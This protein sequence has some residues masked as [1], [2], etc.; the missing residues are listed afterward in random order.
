MDFDSAF[1]HVVIVEKGFQQDPRDRG[2]WTGGAVGKGVCKG[3]KFGISA[4]AYPAENI[5]NLT[6]DRARQIYH[7]DYWGPAGCD[8]APAELKLD[9]FDVA[10]NSGVRAALKLLQRAV[11]ETPDGILGPRT[12]QAVQSMQPLMLRLRF[13]GE[14]LLFLTELPRDTWDAFGR[15]LVARVAGLMVKG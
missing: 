9:L 10:V 1:A 6:L 13:A 5:E 7:R 3:T 12:L 2:N 15:G 8:A 11:G 14:R 4:A